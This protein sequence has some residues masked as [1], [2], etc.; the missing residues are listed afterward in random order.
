M[1]IQIGDGRRITR[2]REEE[3]KRKYSSKLRRRNI[4]YNIS[5]S[6]FT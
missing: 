6:L 5:K 3:E 1:I 2:K 4:R